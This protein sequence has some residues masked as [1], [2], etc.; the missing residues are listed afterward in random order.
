MRKALSVLFLFG[1]FWLVLSGF[2][3]AASDNA[4]DKITDLY[5][6]NARNWEATLKT[7][8]LSL[9]WLLATIEF[10]FAA[11][12][13]A[14]K[15]ADF[16]E[17]LSEV[18][19]Q[20][21]FIG[22]FFTLLVNASAWAGAIVNSFRKA[23]VGAAQDN[24][25]AAGLA[26]S[27]IFDVGMQ[28][29]GKFVEATSMWSPGASLGLFLSALVVIVCFAL[30]A[31]F[32]ILALVE[33]YIV[34]SAGVL[35]MGF[36]ASRWTKD[37]ALK[38]I[39]YAV[40]VGAKLFILQLLVALGAQIFRD[41]ATHV[42]TN[43]A[44]LFVIIGSSI[45]LLA[46]TII[47]PNMVQGLINGTSF[48][49]SQSALASKGVAGAATAT[50]GSTVLASG[51]GRLASAQLAQRDAEGRSPRGAMGRAGYWTMA[52]VRNMGS[53]LVRNIGHRLGGRAA[54]GN[55][56]GQAGMALHEQ[57]NEMRGRQRENAKQNGGGQ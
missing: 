5:R 24:H 21:L 47:V 34:I 6:D 45:V 25:V 57:A 42:Q 48:G 15:G 38:I 28:V 19:T 26:P 8:A 56:V 49:E 37:F 7:Y 36:G 55:R 16:S 20:V 46:L 12:R 50:A 23:A 32:L 52:T 11:L 31:A 29:A 51:A 13:M 18:V 1:V 10:A 3:W 53:A 14:F 22:F 9:F 35:F 43:N 41:L 44:S 27:D 40:S 39:V 4:L 33:S 17:W 2:V 54:F 30:I